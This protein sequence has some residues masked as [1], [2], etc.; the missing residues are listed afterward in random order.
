MIMKL[1]TILTILVLLLLP[2]DA[3]SAKKPA[4]NEIRLTADQVSG[5]NDIEAAIISAT[6]MGTH[7]G[8]VILDG[9]NGPF[10]YTAPDKSLNIF[11]SS[12]NLRG[13]NHAA[14]TNCDDGL[15]FE[16]ASI[17]DIL[18][19]NITFNCTGDGVEATGEFHAVTL[20][21]NTI[22]AAYNGIG[23]RG[24]S[25]GW[26]ITENL[27]QAGWDGIRMTGAKDIEINKNDISG[28]NGVIVLIGSQYEVK[29]NSIRA[30]FQGIILGQEAW[31]NNAQA[32]HIS[33]VSLAGIALEPSVTNNR[34]LSNKVE[35]AS[36]ISCL[37]VDISPIAM[38]SNKISGNTLK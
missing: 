31:Q 10:L 6:D 30:M 7:Q 17:H 36:G 16:G 9:R 26:V 11:V 33:G 12:L 34:V 20:R 38:Q 21:K 28:T 3:A 24:A 37:A 18:I 25:T 32:N 19:E 29:S 22:Q 27:I 8:T 13:E 4:K 23:T 15:F 1:T 14:I 5:A 2:F 35:C